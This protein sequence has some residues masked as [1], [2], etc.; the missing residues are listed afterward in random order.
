MAD[1]TG[2][3]VG[4]YWGPRRETL[5]ECAHRATRFLVE[6]QTLDPA[7]ETWFEK[8]DTRREALRR[9]VAPALP[10]VTATLAA[11]R[12]RDDFRGDPIEEL[13]Y[14]LDLWNGSAISLSISCGMYPQTPHIGNCVVLKLESA[15]SAPS[16][17]T[18]LGARALMELM[19]RSWSPEWATW[20]N[21][22][23]RQEQGWV[24]KPSVGWM[25]YLAEP[26]PVD[27]L[28]APA[29][30]ARVGGGLLVP[31]APDVSNVNG[32]ALMELRDILVPG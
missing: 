26:P 3:H 29:S 31:A 20:T 25:T 17:F 22:A 15:T 6:L 2:C 21:R 5:D 1:L 10:V 27:E 28:P 7:F 16:V 24:G 30:A 23:W 9:R 13:G 18:E 19:V 4:A 12:N 8:G 32:S 14:G 11:G